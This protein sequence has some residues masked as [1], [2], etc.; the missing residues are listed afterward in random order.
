M[1]DD[2]NSNRLNSLSDR[3]AATANQSDPL[4]EL[5]RLIGQND[6]FADF[7]RD[8]R[9]AA[10]P[11]APAPPRPLPNESVLAPPSYYDPRDTF[12][13]PPQPAQPHQQPVP[14][15]I[16]SA[17]PYR[18]PGYHEQGHLP[19]DHDFDLGET[20]G[21]HRK[22]LNKSALITLAVVGIAGAV[23]YR[24]MFGDS[25]SSAP[26]KV[27]YSN[28]E[29]TKV[30]PPVVN[31]DASTNKSNTD[32]VGGQPERLATREEQPVDV[33][34]L[35]RQGGRS[36][37]QQP[38]VA[39]G[40]APSN[41]P[42]SAAMTA[43][44]AVGEPKRVRTVTIRPSQPNAEMGQGLLPPQGSGSAAPQA[45][46]APPP[47]AARPLPPAPSPPTQQRTATTVPP[48][49]AN[50]PLSLSGDTPS[51][52]PPARRTAA[53]KPAP[54]PRPL[55]PPA[56]TANQAPQPLA[57]GAAPKSVGYVVQVSSQRSEAEAQAS[58]RAVQAKYPNVLGGQQTTIRR[59]D[60]GERGTFYRAMVGPFAS[61]EQAMQVCSSLKAAGGNCIV[62]PN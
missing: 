11:A 35:S 38:P 62:P 46:P 56:E 3:P 49:P 61:R 19:Q 23:G 48:P 24:V 7:G 36:Q 52:P 50:A 15:F 57:Q 33:N 9:A 8:T 47:Q 55:T 12:T 16:Q 10:P 2:S 34:S 28:P 60:L 58:L 53:P 37:P 26:P 32:R 54:A 59:A 4:A 40:T 20:G 21:R 44:S 22:F 51:T 30:P 17:G 13:A 45:P 1:A 41:Q 6:P 43:P 29:P 25:A 31:A 18:N 14:S 42:G 5:A 39:L 27:I